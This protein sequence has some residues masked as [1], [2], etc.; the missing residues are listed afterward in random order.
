MKTQIDNNLRVYQVVTSLGQQVFCN[1]TDL[2]Q[3][4]KELGCREGYFK[5]YHFW[6]NKAER[7]TKK[8]LLAFFEGS[9]LKQEF[10]Y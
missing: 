8:N 4:I 9:Q 7:V 5:I 3:V 1:I 2:N 10:F 6:N